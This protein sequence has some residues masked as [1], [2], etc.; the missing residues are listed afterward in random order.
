MYPEP[1][2]RLV[3]AEAKLL[4][5]GHALMLPGHAPVA[6]T[7]VAV[8]ES[9]MRVKLAEDAG[10][11]KVTEELATVPIVMIEVDV[12]MRLIFSALPPHP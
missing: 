5:L 9:P 1:P 12:S 3:L 11:T 7:E 8:V 2:M 4:E 10:S 6:E